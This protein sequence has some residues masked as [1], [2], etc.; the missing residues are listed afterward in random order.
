[1]LF[2]NR[3]E[4]DE[5]GGGW[6]GRGALKVT[7]EARGREPIWFPPGQNEK[8]SNQVKHPI[9]M[10]DTLMCYA[11]RHESGRY[12]HFGGRNDHGSK[13]PT[14]G[15]RPFSPWGGGGG[16]IQVLCN[17]PQN[18]FGH[19]PPRMSGQETSIYEVLGANELICELCDHLPK[20]G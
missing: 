9:G 15:I 18:V 1:M 13:W 14:F 4:M 8:A 6:V 19:T 2:L 7:T 17:P 20:V 3:R 16:T 10:I 5:V 12:V 11:M